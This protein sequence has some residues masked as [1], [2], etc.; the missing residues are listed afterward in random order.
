M[1]RKPKFKPKITRVKLNPEQAV[2]T[3]DCYQ[4]GTKPI[5]LGSSRDTGWLRQ[6]TPGP[7][8]QCM[9]KLQLKW[10]GPYRHYR[11]YNLSGS[12]SSS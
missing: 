4:G 3:C 5:W 12:Q 1:G 2:L 8:A 6:T 11:G 10:I 7:Q 9:G